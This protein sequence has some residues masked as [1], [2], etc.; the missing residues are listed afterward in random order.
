MFQTNL[1]FISH[2]DVWPWGNWVSIQ[3]AEVPQSE[4]LPTQIGGA[5]LKDLAMA[6]LVQTMLSSAQPDLSLLEGLDEIPTFRK[7]LRDHLY[8]VKDGVSSAPGAPDLLRAA[9]AGETFLDWTRFLGIAPETIM[10]A[11]QGPELKDTT[12][13]A[14]CPDW[15]C[16]AASDLA[17]AIC[18]L[19]QLRDLYVMEFP[20]R[21]SEGPIGELYIALAANARCPTGH[22]F[23]SGAASCAFKERLWLPTDEPFS[24]MPSFPISQL[25]VVGENPIPSQSMIPVVYYYYLGDAFLTPL[26]FV[27]GLIR[28]LGCTLGSQMRSESSWSLPAAYLFPC[29]A[30]TLDD[31]FAVS[32]SPLSAETFT[33]AK[34]SYQSSAFSGCFAKMRDLA[35][36]TWTALVHV[37]DP[38]TSRPGR[39][40]NFF[41]CAFIRSKN[42]PIKADPSNP[43]PFGPDDL[44]ILDLESFLQAT[45]PD[46]DIQKFESRLNLFEE[47]ARAQASFLN[48][49]GPPTDPPPG[50]RLLRT[51]MDGD[52]AYKLVKQ[53]IDNLPNVHLRYQISMTD[54]A[55]QAFWYPEL[56]LKPV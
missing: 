14:L 7:S 30:P 17:R 46:A 15:S 44:E 41:Q 56:E 1:F 33:I 34:R 9:F 54:L 19:P 35:P 43:T 26:R 20:G 11:L 49:V 37:T 55:P 28:F 42:G 27:D 39:R 5:S 24:P 47:L 23:L 50:P 51:R 13:L 2:T 53:A 18:T 38:T 29:A 22:I 4:K 16:T 6:K 52:T 8:A 10:A 31:D 45:A 21:A 48:Y 40:I 12:G 3:P 36:D 25:L 32:I